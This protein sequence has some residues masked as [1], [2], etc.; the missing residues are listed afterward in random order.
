MSKSVVENNSLRALITLAKIGKKIYK[1]KGKISKTK[2]KKIFKEE[3]LD[4]ADDVMTLLD[5]D[6][7][8]D[9]A[10]ALADLVIGTD[11]NSKKSRSLRFALQTK[12]Y[13]RDIE[14]ITGRKQPAKQLRLLK[15]D[16]QNNKYSRLS[17]SEVKANRKAFENK[18][19]KLIKEWERNT[20]QKW[21][22]DSKT[23][24]KYDTHH[25]VEVKFGGKHEWW[26]IHPAKKGSEH[27]GGIHSTESSKVLFPDL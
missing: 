11:L 25:I 6:I 26:N 5:G 22:I 15:E 10:F 21:P 2:L 27:Q 12:R 14:K 18:R 3:A 7:T 17:V 20:G 23:G 9:D 1:I 13:I 8:V 19:L 4:I 16:F 24:N